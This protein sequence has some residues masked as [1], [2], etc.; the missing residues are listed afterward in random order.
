MPRHQ[1]AFDFISQV[2][3]AKTP[4]KVISTLARAV[5]DFGLER[6]MIASI[7][8]P[9]SRFE[10]SIMLHN[11]P[12]GWFDRYM[13]Q[14]Y[15]AVDPVI[16]RLRS[17]T[18][19]FCWSEA[20]YDPAREPDA[21]RVMMEA[22][23][24][25]LHAGFT[26]PIFTLSGDQGGVTFGGESVELSVEDRAALHLIGIYAHAR[27]T[28]LRY[29]KVRLPRPRLSP[30]EAEVLKW[31]AAGRTSRDIGEILSISD[32]TVE[33]YIAL[34]CRKLDA[35]NRTHAVAEAIRQKL[36]P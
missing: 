34:A 12:R 11:W 20:P 14:H 21:H 35:L 4:A 23:E 9:T 29:P 5:A 13:H 27:T 33:T 17:S 7:P 3:K 28:E 2:D 16:R 1:H 30:R 15:L 10:P 25:K 22:T 31:C 8:A 36:I 26:I 6:F 18:K 32:T 24:F 19:P